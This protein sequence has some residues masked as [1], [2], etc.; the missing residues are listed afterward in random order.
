MTTL[1]KLGVV[2][3]R[4]AQLLTTTLGTFSLDVPFNSGAAPITF[5]QGVIRAQTVYFH[6]YR[7][8]GL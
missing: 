2:G 5:T 8:K 1:R 3:E 4:V 7:Y 6:T